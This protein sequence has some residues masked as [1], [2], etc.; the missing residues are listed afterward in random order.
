MSY[1]YYVSP[2]SS[3][4]ST[5]TSRAMDKR[6]PLEKVARWVADKAVNTVLDK[7][8][9]RIL[10][11]PLY[12]LISAAVA[13]GLI[14]SFVIWVI[15]DNFLP[16]LL[17][18]PTVAI[19]I[20]VGALAGAAMGGSRG[21]LIGA[22]FGWLVAILA[23]SSASEL[24]KEKT[25]KHLDPLWAWCIST[26]IGG[27]TGWTAER[28][29]DKLAERFPALGRILRV[30]VYLAI[31]VSIAV[32]LLRV[33]ATRAL[34]WV[35]DIGHLQSLVVGAVL[36]LASIPFY[37]W[38][39]APDSILYETYLIERVSDPPRW[40]RVNLLWLQGLTTAMFLTL[41]VFGPAGKPGFGQSLLVIAG[42]WTAPWMLIT[43]VSLAGSLVLRLFD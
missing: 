41:A 1:S 4:Y 9:S 35:P 3:N 10:A 42:L 11:G 8:L 19:P 32:V 12:V 17:S 25:E 39:Y 14:T 7:I 31:F 33:G 13:T 18:S 30:F 23:E 26:T 40:I 21:L 38:C 34:W 28:L 5:P 2:G 43:A 24:S 27:L 37:L 29:S 6:P 15:V 16:Q 36:T 20:A 22:G